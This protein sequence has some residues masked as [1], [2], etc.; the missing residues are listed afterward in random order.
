MM[1]LKLITFFE[2]GFML[3]RSYKLNFVAKYLATF[4][5]VVFYFFL[6]EMFRRA[7]VI[8]AGNDYFTFVLIGGAFSKYVE[9]GMR[10]LSDT[11]REEMLLGT[12]EPLLATATPLTLALLGPATFIV[13]EGTLLVSAQLLI[14]AAFGADFS[15][16]N[17]LAAIG[18]TVL[19]VGCLFCWGVIS[20]AFTLRY[21]RHDPINWIVGAISYVFSGVFFPVSTLPP[22]LQVISAVLP[23]TYALR[24]LRGA[25][26]EGK[27]LLDLGTDIGALVLFTVVLLPIA[28]Y[29][30]NAA[31]RYLKQSGALG[32]Y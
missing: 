18:M 29:S 32:H 28:L 1:A 25:L 22:A 14:G 8:V 5:T 20:A 30:V 11:L 17:W 9:I 27:G 19:L 15:R 26:R 3:A 4:V 2:H 31:A 23:F 16:A 21:K 13:A 6:A 12:L 7:N 24:G 10:T